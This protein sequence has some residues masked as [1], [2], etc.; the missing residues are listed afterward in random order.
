VAGHIRQ[1]WDP[2]MRRQLLAEL[3]AGADVNPVVRAAGE[4]TRQSA[5]AR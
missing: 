2:R 3:D 5:N 1:F 4:L